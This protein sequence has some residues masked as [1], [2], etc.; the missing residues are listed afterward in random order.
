M[1][2]GLF[3]LAADG[4]N[5]MVG[6]A[7]IVGDGDTNFLMDVY[8]LP[9]HQGRGLGVAFLSVVLD[10]DGRNRWRWLLHTG[11]RKDWYVGKLG[12]SVVGD[13]GRGKML[14]VPIYILERDGLAIEAA[15][16]AGA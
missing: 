1:T 10:N 2:F 11:D 6:M 14:G 12:F 9:E 13:A 16:K 5:T 4:T 3:H 7:R 15:Q 8:V